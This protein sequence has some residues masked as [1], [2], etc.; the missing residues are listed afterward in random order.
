MSLNTWFL[1]AASVAAIA[2]S[3]A[4]AMA[5]DLNNFSGTLSGH[6]A[7]INVKGGGPSMDSYGA[8]GSGVFSLGTSGLNLQGDLGYNHLSGGGSS[9]AW[10]FALSPF[11]SLENGRIG[12]TVGY[13]TIDHSVGHIYNYGGYGEW[14]ASPMFTLAA[15][16]GGFSGTATN[17]GDYV[18]GGV[19]GYLTPNLAFNGNINYA[20]FNNAGHE[21]D[22]TLGAE[23]LFGDDMPVSIYGGWTR[24]EF[25]GISTNADT[26]FVG[27]RFYT[28]GNGARTLVQRHRTGT[29]NGLQSFG[30]LMG[31]Y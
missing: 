26:F 20:D 27:L 22:Y 2:I 24:S 8:D 19:T 13:T 6:Y 10:N 4:P 5:G 9:N 12:A 18:G 1:A 31:K 3:S 15:K 7:N 11:M 17:S 14:F 29:L 16:G 30:P 21:T 25:S 23:Y 28:N